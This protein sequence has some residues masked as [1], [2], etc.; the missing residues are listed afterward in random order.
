MKAARAAWWRLGSAIFALLAPLSVHAAPACS[1][2]RPWLAA[3]EAM[4]RLER[5]PN[6]TAEALKTASRNEIAA[7]SAS[8]KKFFAEYLAGKNIGLTIDTCLT[9]LPDGGNYLFTLQEAFFDESLA[10]LRASR[11]PTIQ[12]LVL[13]LDRKIADGLAPSFRLTGLAFAPDDP[14]PWEAGFHRGAGSIY[15]DFRK[16]PANE[17]L[18]IFAHEMLHGLDDELARA[19]TEFN[20]P[21]RVQRLGALSGSAQRTS[22]LTGS[23]SV[24]LRGWIE[25]GLSRGLWAEY[26]AWV[27]SL[28]LYREGVLEGLWRPIPW[29]ELVLRQQPAGMR[30][31]RFVYLYLDQNSPDPTDGLFG[32]PLVHSALGE[33]RAEYRANDITP[34]REV[35]R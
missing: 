4:A 5:S 29:V 28:T 11:S 9:P 7:R 21:D 15:A 30:F 18:L 35:L 22:Q 25:A 27:P 23:Q 10:R 8:A 2:L 19:T 33:I 1:E 20:D 3:R 6:E 12:K 31:E 26:R 16:I 14:G 24:D 13:A 32:D 17:W 34:G